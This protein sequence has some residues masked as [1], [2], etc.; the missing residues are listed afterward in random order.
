MS[1]KMT[2]VRLP[3]QGVFIGI[4]DWGDVDVSEM[5]NQV[6]WYADHLR[7]EI[8][9][10]DAASDD[11]FQVEVVKGVHRQRLLNVKQSSSRQLGTGQ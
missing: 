5:I 9:A 11:E 2:R 1:E 8:A 6:R 4:Q 10:I 3:G 7:A